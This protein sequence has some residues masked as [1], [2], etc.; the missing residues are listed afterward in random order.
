MYARVTL[1]EI[2]LVRADVDELLD[3]YRHEVLPEIQAQPGYEG[4]LVLVNDDGQG[5]IVSLWSDEEALESTTPLASGAIERFMTVFR[6]PPG[7]ESYE[8]RLADVPSLAID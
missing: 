3:R 1:C 4:M 6:A 7:R 2:D 5:M 8:L